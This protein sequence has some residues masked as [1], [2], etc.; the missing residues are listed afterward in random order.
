VVGARRCG[1]VW[2]GGC[3][4]GETFVRGSCHISV[5]WRGGVVVGGGGMS[6]GDRCGELFA[7]VMMNDEFH[8]LSSACHVA[9]SDVAPETIVNNSIGVVRLTKWPN[10]SNDD[11]CRCRSSS[12]RCHVARRILMFPRFWSWPLLG[13][14]AWSWLL[15]SW[16]LF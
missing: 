8:C 7:V 6:V 14:V 13:G 1:A 16:L 4:V 5:C 3:G 10:T 12:S 9:M 15:L 2:R 11:I